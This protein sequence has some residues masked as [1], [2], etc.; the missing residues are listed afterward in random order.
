[1]AGHA[2]PNTTISQDAFSVAPQLIGLPLASAKRRAAAM[3]VDLLIVAVLVNLGGGTLLGLGAAALFFSMATKR[4]ASGRKLSLVFRGV[5]AVVLFYMALGL[6]HRAT[7]AMSSAGSSVVEALA[8]SS[9]GPAVDVN[10]KKVPVASGLLIAPD[11]LELE[12]AED[13]PAAEAAAKKLVGHMHGAG[14]GE[15]EIRG[16][17]GDLAR[18]RDRP[19][20]GEVLS[21]ATGLDLAPKPVPSDSL[22]IAYGAALAKKDAPAAAQLRPQLTAALA[23]DTLADAEARI[24]KLE[25][26]NEE[27]KDAAESAKDQPGPGILKVLGNAA[28][29]LG[30]SFGWM[31]LYFTGFLALWQGQTPGKRIAGIRVMRLGGEKITFWAA[32]ERY[33]GYA[34]SVFTGLLGFAQILWDRNRQALHD[35]IVE[36][37]VVRV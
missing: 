29:D 15:R 23:A 24:G 9:A 28:D 26:A 2:S 30:L 6:W 11:M 35:K 12:K 7:R 1:M 25:S 3:A 34:A 22:A 21:G 13:R 36:T 5:G 33:G 19:W 8:T 37:V 31:A 32:F 16:A 10:G 20:M 14:M 18:D 27:L 17:V 4:A